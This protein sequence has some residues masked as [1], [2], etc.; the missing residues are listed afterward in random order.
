M[1]TILT[2]AAIIGLSAAAPVEQYPVL[3]DQPSEVQFKADNY[4]TTLLECAI[5]NGEE[6]VKY[7]WH[8]NGAPFDWESAG[9]IAQRKG[10]GSIMF[11]N[12]QPSDEGVY[13]CFAKTSSGTAS[14]KP[15][16]LKR[17]YIN[18]PNVETKE[19]SPVF[20]KPYKL[21]CKIPD[22]YP[23]PTIVWK[24]QLRSDPSI[25]E[26]IL[27]RRITLSP[28]ANLW[29]SNITEEDISP[30]F[31]YICVAQ[32][33]AAK[34]DVV[35]A[36]HFLKDLV[37][38]DTPNDGELVPQYVSNDMMA[39]AGDVTMIYCIY[40]GTP[41]AYPTWFKDGKEIKSKPGD[42]VTVY[43]RTSG[44]RLLIR[45]TILEDQG[46]YKCVVSNEV[47]KPQTHSM[48]LT[49]VS[50]PK[51]TRKAEKTIIAKAGDDVTIP[52]QVT[53]LPEPKVTW[54]FNTKPLENASVKDGVLTIKQIKKS[55]T[56]YYGCK[57]VNEHG[58]LYTETLVRVD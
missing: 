5:D 40:G 19:H 12:P 36:E 34:D 51:F 48:Q 20:G 47:G 18:Q 56:G 49:V 57:A 28:D 58:D 10:E 50:A 29:F 21:D 27:S 53:G 11:F 3:K 2:L 41:L 17:V 31:K 26:T 38:E 39:K 37:R 32:T 4:S 52:C 1:K 43:N 9:H 54:T 55:D 44:K 24:T 8:K 30:S 45:D 16:N 6:D 25:T 46:R 13:Q 22:A 33:P 7:T 35:L 15:I 23:K 14:T 42:R